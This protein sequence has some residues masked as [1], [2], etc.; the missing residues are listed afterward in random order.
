MILL[1]YHLQ[2]YGVLL[3]ILPG[4]NPLMQSSRIYGGHMHSCMGET[5][6]IY[7][8]SKGGKT[9]WGPSRQILQPRKP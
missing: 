2:N 8:I 6:S 4:T 1:V 7:C 5:E 9:L 3:Y